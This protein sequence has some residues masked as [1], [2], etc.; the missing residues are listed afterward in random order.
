MNPQIRMTRQD[1]EV[2]VHVKQGHPCTN[3]DG[4]DEAIDQLANSFPPSSTK[5]KQRGRIIKIRRNCGDE[6]GAREQPAQV[7]QV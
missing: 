5:T 4:G 1:I 6:G 7:V 3:R 2:T